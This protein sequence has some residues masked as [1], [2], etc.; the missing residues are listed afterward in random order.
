[1]EKSLY[2]NVMMEIITMVMDVQE[3]VKYKQ[4][5]LVLEVTLTQKII[6]MF[7]DQIV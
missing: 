2:L 1:M 3:I 5:L 6:A 4:V 7:L